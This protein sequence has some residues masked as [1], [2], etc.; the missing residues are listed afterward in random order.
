MKK[1]VAIAFMIIPA[2]CLFSQQKTVRKPPVIVPPKTQ[3]PDKWFG[4]FAGPNLNHLNYSDGSTTIG[5]SN[6]GLHAGIFFQKNINKYFAI[7][8]A[9]LFSLRGGEIRN[10]DSTTNA[11]LMNI[12]LPV[13]F[14]YLYKHVMFGGGPNF[15]YSLNG[16]LKTNDSERDAFDAHESFER[17]LKRVEFGGNLL[18]G[19]AFKKGFFITAN[20][21]PGFTNIY[22]G[23]GS[24]PSNVKA[25]TQV[26]GL[27]VGYQLG[28]MSDE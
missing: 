20:Y 10:V 5:G 14:L 11:R 4:I 3:P 22:E 15:S 7:Q 13:N 9:L 17:T 12:E 23:D 16:R 21:S 19:Y 24:A 26:F 28:I 25:N 2:S 18:I 27:S 1:I 6:T 8:P